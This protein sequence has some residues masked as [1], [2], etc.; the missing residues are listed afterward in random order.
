MQQAEGDTAKLSLPAACSLQDGNV[1]RSSEV[2]MR[3]QYVFLFAAW[4]A[5]LTPWGCKTAVEPSPEPGILR[6]MLKGAESDTRIIIQS[7]TS[8]FSRWDNFNLVVNQGRAYQGDNYA[9]V[10]NN[11]TSDRKSS[12]TVNI[13]AREWLNGVP[14]TSQ[15]SDSITTANS[16]FRNYVIFESY[17][18]PGT[19]T[20]FTFI[21]TA[22]EMEIFIPKHYLNPVSLPPDLTPSLE[23][24]ASFSVN[25]QGVTEIQLEISPYASLT[26]YQDQFYFQRKIA[27]TGIQQR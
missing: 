12:D 18:P 16:R 24:P 26:R 11:P 1:S 14:I 21:M 27:I 3:N 17:V 8:R 5:L 7:D 25:E 23:F 19:Y 6:V 13:L 22:S 20:K 2:R 4:C 9:Y 10:Y 15:D